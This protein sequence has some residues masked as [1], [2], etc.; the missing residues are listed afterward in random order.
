MFPEDNL[1]HAC[2]RS[3][4]FSEAEMNKARLA[5]M[6]LSGVRPQAEFYLTERVLTDT[7]IGHIMVRLAFELFSP[8]TTRMNS[9][10]L[11]IK[12]SRL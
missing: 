10:F 8:I 7:E 5:S 9:T 6:R 11:S 4:N 3:A 2:S 1:A 12:V